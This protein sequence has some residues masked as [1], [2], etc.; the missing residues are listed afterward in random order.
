[1]H[2]HHLDHYMDDRE[3]R[4]PSALLTCGLIASAC[5]Q[6]LPPTNFH[7]AT[8]VTSPEHR[9]L[10]VAQPGQGAIDVLRVH[11]SGNDAPSFVARLHDPKRTHILR[12][13]V[14]R[15]RDRLWV[16]D[17]WL[18][19]VYELAGLK[20]V[21]R[22]ELERNGPYYERFSDLVLDNDGNAFILARG[23][24]RIYRI[25][26]TSLE[27]ERWLEL[28]QRVSD[29]AVLLANRVLKSPD[30]R[31][32]LLP[33]PASGALLRVD[34]RTR[35]IERGV[36][37]SPDL[38]CGLLLWGATTRLHAFD[39]TGRWDVEMD[40]RGPKGIGVVVRGERRRPGSVLEFAVR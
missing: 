18:V 2:L 23:G 25:G 26:T 4:Y 30:D 14:D 17:F 7:L 5:S 3:V 27:L 35:Q 32:L 19:Q 33:A 13:A 22:Y 40:L 15:K 38:T 10:F 37:E 31:Y 34:I 21:R 24:A 1:M 29:A 16:A 36:A 11:A 12:L 39:C 28:D 9:F 6:P 20:E 8:V